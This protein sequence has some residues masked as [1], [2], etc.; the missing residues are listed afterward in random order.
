MS[1]VRTPG[2]IELEGLTLV[3]GMPSTEII[4]KLKKS[5]EHLKEQV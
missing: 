2:I 4:E 5:Y 1:L 3:S